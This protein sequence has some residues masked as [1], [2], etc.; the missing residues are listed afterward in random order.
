M[1]GSRAWKNVDQKVKQCGVKGWSG[2]MQA[3]RILQCFTEGDE[4]LDAALMLY[5]RLEAHAR[6]EGLSKRETRLLAERL[7]VL[8]AFRADNPT[9]HYELSL[10]SVS[11][12]KKKERKRWK[13]F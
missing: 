5:T 6:P 8:A 9:G 11:W 2:C 7:G 1:K 12:S 3:G 13:N 10:P 4:K